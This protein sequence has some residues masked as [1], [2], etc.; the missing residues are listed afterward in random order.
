MA[1]VPIKNCNL[2]WESVLLIY[3]YIYMFCLVRQV[4]KAKAQSDQEMLFSQAREETE[5][6]H[7]KV[8]RWHWRWPDINAIQ[9]RMRPTGSVVFELCCI[10]TPDVLG[11]PLVAT[12]LTLLIY[13]YILD[14]LWVWYP[15]ENLSV[16]LMS[17]Q[18]WKW[19]WAE[20]LQQHRWWMLYLLTIQCQ[21]VYSAHSVILL[22][23]TYFYCSFWSIT[24]TLTYVMH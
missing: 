3:V 5:R 12:G 21:K 10:E 22:A 13:I 14:Q 15:L 4:N 16:M 11:R 23:Y 18:F 17:C 6:L 9:V 2:K 1:L 7:I 19:S 8:K 24:T 20:S